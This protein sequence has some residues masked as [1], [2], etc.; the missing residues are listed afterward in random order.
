MGQIVCPYFTMYDGE[1][2][3]YVV[4]HENDILATM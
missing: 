1:G 3:E 4:L 2:K